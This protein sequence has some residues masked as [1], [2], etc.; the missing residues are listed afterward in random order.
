MTIARPQDVR[1]C[2]HGAVIVPTR[3]PARVLL[4]VCSVHEHERSSFT[5][6]F[7]YTSTGGLTI[8]S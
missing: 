4:V 5:M 7:P 1:H 3:P 8:R 2:S 6:L